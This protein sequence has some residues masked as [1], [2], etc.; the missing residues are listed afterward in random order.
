ASVCPGED[1]RAPTSDC[2]SAYQW[3]AAAWNARTAPNLRGRPSLPWPGTG[4][5]LLPAHDPANRHRSGWVPFQAF[6]P[7][8]WTTATR[9]QALPASRERP[10]ALPW[11]LQ[12]HTT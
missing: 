9:L 12:E 7:E 3:T 6:P 5:A 1:G 10:I 2:A 4:A 11:C 8:A